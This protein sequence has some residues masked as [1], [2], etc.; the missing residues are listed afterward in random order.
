MRIQR[1]VITGTRT[2][3]SPMRKVVIRE[4]TNLQEQLGRCSLIH[5]NCPTGVDREADRIGKYFGWE[6]IPVDADW[7][8]FGNYAGPERNKRMLTQYGHID[9]VLGFPDLRGPSKGTWNCLN[10]AKDLRINYQVFFR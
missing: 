8:Q 4:I 6:V 3:D 2:N 9:K 7:D 10:Q 5:G 1:F